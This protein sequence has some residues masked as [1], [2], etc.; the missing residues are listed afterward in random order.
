ME[1]LWSEEA[2][3]DLRH[4]RLFLEEHAGRKVARRIGTHLIRAVEELVETP[5]RGRPGRWTG[6][7]ELVI[8]GTPYLIPYR[9]RGEAIEILR[10][11]HG[12]RRFPEEPEASY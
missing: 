1:I 2:R 10:V 6:T 7:R 3:D 12:A 11:F 5:H 8:T 9:V 4:I